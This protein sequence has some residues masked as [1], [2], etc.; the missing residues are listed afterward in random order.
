MDYPAAVL[1]E[2]GEPPEAS[3]SRPSKR[4]RLTPTEFVC[5]ICYDTPG[6]EDVF[7]LRCTHAFC[8]TCWEMYMTSKV[9]EEGQCFFSCMQ[10]GCATIVDDE[11]VARFTD[12]AGYDR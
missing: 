9:K 6:T 7:K 10:D 5:G 3:A 1:K 8:T 2:A 11:A 4:T 12:T